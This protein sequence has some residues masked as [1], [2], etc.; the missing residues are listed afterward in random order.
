MDFQ[1]VQKYIGNL[2]QVFSVKEY[3]ME[4]GKAK[5]IYAVDINNGAGLE[6]TILPDR[7][8][9]FYQLKYNGKSLNYISPTGP[10]SPEYSDRSGENWLKSYFAGFLTTCGLS[11]I[12]VPCEDNGDVLGLHGELSNTPAEHVNILRRT[13]DGVPVVYISGTMRSAVL[14]GSNLSLTRTVT[15]KYG[16]NRIRIRDEIRN[17][18]YKTSPFMTLY[19]FNM[20]YPLLCEQSILEIPSRSVMPRNEHA[21]NHA[22]DYLKITAPVSPYEEMCYYHELSADPQGN[23]CVGIRNPV[24]NI[25]VTIGFNKNVLD[26]FVQWKM[27]GSSEYVIGLEPCN[28]TIDGRADARKNGSLKFIEPKQAITHE[29]EVSVTDDTGS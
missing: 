10:V 15:M 14:F 3:R 9:D 12:G 17:E 24:E 18:G 6:L 26:H 27:L 25:R 4:G 19:H 21:A 22:E 5:G 1:S 16:E 11:N 13:E 29:L 7:C 28:A 2:S 23:T 20:G 8:M